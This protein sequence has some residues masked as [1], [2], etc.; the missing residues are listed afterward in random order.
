MKNFFKL[1]VLILILCGL[2]TPDTAHAETARAVRS[3]QALV[4]DGQMTELRGYSI[5]GYNYY[6]LR[7]L[8]QILK[9]KVDFDLKGDDKQ[10]VVDRTK[11]YQSFPGDQS[12]SAKERALLHPMRLKVLGDNPADVIEN[13]YNIR[14]FNYFRL[15]SVGTVLGFDVSFDEGKNLALITTNADRK[16]A[17]APSPAPQAPTGRVILGNERLFTE[18][19]SLIDNKRVGLITNQTGVD[20]KGVPVAEKIKAYPNA[21]LVALYSPEHGLDGKQ[22]AG[23]YV[24]S[25]YDKKMNLPV[26]S[27]YGPTRKPSRDMLKG[28][29]VL[30]YD[31]QDIGSRT[32]TYISTLQNVMLA[33]K[34]NNI[35]IVVLDRPNPLGGE[36]VEG[37]L[38]ETRF[39][40]FVGIDKMPM[41][42]GM[43]V[44]ELGQFFN[45]E[46]GADLTVVPMKNWTRSMVWQ[47]TGLPFAQTSPNIPNLESAFL[48]M[49]TGSGEETGIGQ[50]EYFRWVGGRNINSNEYARRLNGANLPG[51]TFTPAPKGSRGGVRLKV[52]DWHTFNPA[53]TGIYTLAVANQMRPMNVPICKKPYSMFY[54]VQ[55]SEEIARLFRAG[56]SPETI[57]KAYE[58]DVNAFKAQREPYLLY[59]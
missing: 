9:G 24:A 47:D 41:A 39:K 56:A 31:M 59:K 52:T 37:F 6:R 8:A 17:P 48:Y 58:K 51:V 21:K 32:Y 29:D 28:V 53:R 40:S 2:I 3:P 50:G 57:V 20:A 15:R 43:T 5:G 23:A 42:H 26:Y 49:A 30:V 7:D 35:P 54:L 10:I 11:T 46:I 34:E 33:A 55:G 13:A 25:Y 16:P 36:I 18:Y 38:R 1:S 27:L 14:G 4:V 22:T 19:R 44:G 45:R 12:G